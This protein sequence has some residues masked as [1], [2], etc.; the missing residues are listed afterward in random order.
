[1]T[2]SIRHGKPADIPCLQHIETMAASRF[3]AVGMAY[4]AEDEPTE[5]DRLR[6]RIADGML[7]VAEENGPVGYIGFRPVDDAAYIEEIDVLPE[8]AGQGIGAALI[9]RVGE[10]A[11]ERGLSRLLL[12]TFKY[13]PWNAPYY[14]RLGFREITG[15]RLTAA[16]M[17]IRREHIS[18]GLDETA[19]V[20]M[21]RPLD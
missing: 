14:R 21:E 18:W 3:L 4:I 2:G 12:S 8:H 17:A 19:R 20:F 16:M 6:R 7:F 15:G 10:A 13:V 5:A 9:D 1:M 11:R